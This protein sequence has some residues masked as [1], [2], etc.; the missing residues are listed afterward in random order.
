MTNKIGVKKV[1]SISK[2]AILLIHAVSQIGNLNEDEI[3]ANCLVKVGNR[4]I[5]VITV[6]DV[7]EQAYGLTLLHSYRLQHAIAQSENISFSLLTNPSDS[8]IVKESKGEEKTMY[9][10]EHLTPKSKFTRERW[11]MVMSELKYTENLYPTKDAAMAKITRLGR[12]YE[13]PESNYR[14]VEDK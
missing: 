5:T 2:N 13:E 10:I 4:K 6:K 11:E 8:A 9:R 14:I 7:L 12:A 1:N 3:M